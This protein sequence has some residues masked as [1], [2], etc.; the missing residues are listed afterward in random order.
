MGAIHLRRV[1]QRVLQR[2]GLIAAVWGLGLALS[3]LGLLPGLSALGAILNSRP[4]AAALARGEADVLW[5]EVFSEHPT[6]TVVLMT[7]AACAL[8]VHWLLSLLLSGGLLAALRA[9]GQAEPVLR[10]GA[11]LGEGAR[12]FTAMLRLSL[13]GVLTRVPALLLVAVPLALV[14]TR[15][16]ALGFARSGAVLVAFGLY[17]GLLWCH[18]SVILRCAQAWLAQQPPGGSLQARSALRAALRLTLRDATGRRSALALALGSLGAYAI[19]IMTALLLPRPVAAA[20]FAGL[21]FLLRQLFALGRAVLA[22]TL[23]GA[24]ADLTRAAAPPAAPLSNF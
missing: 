6:L 15:L 24:A 8:L 20:G 16:P 22:L 14:G 5:A 10:G 9:P 7:G 1:L 19:L 18:G 21:A 4:A 13:L 2:P 23:L 12:L 17:A 3:L 11:V